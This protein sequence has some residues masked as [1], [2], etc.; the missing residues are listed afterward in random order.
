MFNNKLTPY[1][2][3]FLAFCVVSSKH[4]IIYN[5]EI[6]VA[7]SFLLFVLFVFYYFGNNVR[8][9]LDERADNIQFE[10][11]NFL[12]LKKDSLNEL[13][14]M[15]KKAYFSKQLLENLFNFTKF[16]LKS[17]SLN[18]GKALKTIFSQQINNKLKNVS[19]SNFNVKTKLQMIL[20]DQLLFSVLVKNKNLSLQKNKKNKAK[21]N[22]TFL[23]HQQSLQ[24]L[25]K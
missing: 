14:K 19:Y 17:K 10:L 13:L 3:A 25:A 12:N 18:Y 4:I 11:Q 9:S 7:L 1:I 5:E 2:F 23:K 15:H 16:K 24:T 8:E 6:L 20:S 22:F 21:L